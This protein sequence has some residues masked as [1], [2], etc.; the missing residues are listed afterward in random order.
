MNTGEI[1][2]ENNKLQHLRGRFGFIDRDI[3]RTISYL[4]IPTQY[5]H[6]DL[7]EVSALV[8]PIG[9]EI[10][11]TKDGVLWIYLKHEKALPLIVQGLLWTALGL[12]ILLLHWQFFP[13]I[14]FS[15]EVF[16]HYV[17]AFFRL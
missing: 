8:R 12:T 11:F 4:Q 3:V 16:N 6:R 5:S 1:L 14:D 15:L 13:E 10:K 17:R 9:G 2:K 7:D